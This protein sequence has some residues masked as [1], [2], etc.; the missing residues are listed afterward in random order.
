MALAASVAFMIHLKNTLDAASINVKKEE[1]PL[2]ETSERSPARSIAGLRRGRLAGPPTR[3]PWGW[4]VRGLA[5]SS[6][7]W[8]DSSENRPVQFS[9]YGF[10]GISDITGASK[11]MFV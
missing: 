2:A 11:T 6:R 1:N 8:A 10:S 7:P 4:R 9:G 5:P 3:A